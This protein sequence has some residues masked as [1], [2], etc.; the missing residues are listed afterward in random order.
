MKA[1]ALKISR[2]EMPEF[3][4]PRELQIYMGAVG[5]AYILEPDREDRHAQRVKE[6][7]LDGLSQVDFNPK[8]EWLGVVEPMGAA[9]TCILALDIVYAD[10][11][12]EEVLACEDVIAQQIN[13]IPK[14]GAW[15]A[16]R[17]GTFGTWEIYKGVRKGPDNIYYKR[18]TQQMTDDG[19]ST[20]SPGYAFARLG[21]GDDRPQKGAYADVLEFTGLDNRYYEDPLLKK[22]YRFLFSA[23]IT[24]ARKN[25]LFGDVGPGWRRG[26]SALLWRVGRFDEQAA[27]YAAW[28]LDG[29]EAPGHLLPYLL[30]KEPLPEAV[31]PQSQLF[32]EGA[33]VFRESADSP[34]SFGAMLY[35][36]TQRAEWHTHEEVNH[37]SL[38]AYGERVLVNG[39]WLGE[40]TRA[41]D[42]NN[43]LSINGQRHK[44]KT[45]AGLVEGLMAEGF[46]Y[47]CGD[48][49]RALGDDHFLRNLFLIHGRDGVPGY[50]VIY[51]EV[52]A[53]PGDKIHL[54][55]QP[56]S[57]QKAEVL[58]SGAHYRS[59]LDHH[60]EHKDLSLDVVYVTPADEV[61]QDLVASGDLQ[62]T[63]KSGKH[64]RLEAV[65]H[66]GAEGKRELLTLL[67]PRLKG[68]PEVEAFDFPEGT[69]AIQITFPDG[70]VD[71]LWLGRP[72][73]ITSV[74]GYLFQG[75]FCYARE[76][77]GVLDAY[78]VKNAT[79][80]AFQKKSLL[81]VESPVTFFHPQQAEKVGVIKK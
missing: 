42:K 66:A 30:M 22:F 77:S 10:L 80:F 76:K 71:T 52:D 35:N 68:Q 64:F 48:S 37:I 16:A 2:G 53:A 69:N 34:F 31:V 43:T 56:A 50:F 27:A 55:L 11:S 70:V 58:I 65:F 19:V 60:T 51:D 39:G 44:S 47:A 28:L 40:P 36:I 14:Q 63:P 57:E 78:F 67:L 38:A 61:K 17:M 32:W 62:R 20:V 49:G 29:T 18:V 74:G 8:K 21:A 13:K 4:R 54:Y 26:T 72:D 6:V 59:V 23:A 25:H 79:R 3:K 81:M 9:F 12:E 73:K 1:K 45:G 33:A 15:P 46:D 5:L 41:P 75:D 7:I 24:P